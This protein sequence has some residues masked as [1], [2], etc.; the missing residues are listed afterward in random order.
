MFSNLIGNALQYSPADSAIA[1][2]IVGEADQ[3]SISVHNDS[4]R[5]PPDQQRSI[6]QSLTRGS[7]SG[8]ATRSTN[9]GLGLFITHKIITAHGGTISVDSAPHVGTTF[10]VTLPRQ[11]KTA[12]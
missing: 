4:E 10:T 7:G 6:F 5:I 2:R 3:M 8:A 11:L 12:E 1:M 9:L